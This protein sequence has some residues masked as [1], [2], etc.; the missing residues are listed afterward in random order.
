MLGL[1]EIKNGRQNMG[2]NSNQNTS[3]YG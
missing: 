3:I 2:H 1:M